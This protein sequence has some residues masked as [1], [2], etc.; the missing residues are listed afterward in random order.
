MKSKGLLTINNM[1]NYQAL[2][3]LLR[4]DTEGKWVWIKEFFKRKDLRMDV[5]INYRDYDVTR[6]SSTWR[7]C[8]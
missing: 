7:Y 1:T 5:A 8:R 4:H 3:W 2:A 6:S